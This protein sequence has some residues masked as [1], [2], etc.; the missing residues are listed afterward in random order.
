MQK[1]KIPANVKAIAKRALNWKEE[2]FDGSTEVG[3]NTAH[4]LANETYVTEAKIRHIAKYFPRHEVDKKAEGFNKGEKGFP[5]KGRVAWEAWGGDEAWIWSR[6]IVE[7]LDK[8]KFI[9][10]FNIL[11]VKE[12]LK[13][14]IKNHLRVILRYDSEATYRSFEPYVVYN[15]TQG[16]TL[17]SGTQ[18]RD[19]KK[20][21]ADAEPHK[22]DLAKINMLRVTK[23][24]FK[25][26]DRFNKDRDEY[27][28]YITMIKPDIVKFEDVMNDKV[29]FRYIKKA[30]RDALPDSDFGY[31]KGDR[32]LFPIVLEE[33]V[34]AASRLLGRANITEAER[35]AAKAKIIKIAKEKGFKLPDTWQV[36]MSEDLTEQLVDNILF[37]AELADIFTIKLDNKLYTLQVVDIDE[38]E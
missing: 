24:A 10:F 18:I 3:W 28:N 27:K 8:A 32:R 21:K 25:Y 38:V 14:A 11:D 17:V 1:F 2:G 35:D 12:K 6:K 30:E 9:T 13:Q 34:L 23:L 5:S 15:S 37:S 36:D 19:Y 4:I 7:R 31:V 29:E 33:D 16:N 26:D 22:F 20:D